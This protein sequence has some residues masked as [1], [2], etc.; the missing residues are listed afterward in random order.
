MNFLKQFMSNGIFTFQFK[1]NIYILGAIQRCLPFLKF[2]E[3]I[4]PQKEKYFLK[5][6]KHYV[7]AKIVFLL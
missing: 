3:N 5:G 2:L 1:N 4:F 6:V 7:T